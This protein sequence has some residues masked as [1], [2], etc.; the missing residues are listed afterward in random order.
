MM[1]RPQLLLLKLAEE[2]AEVSQIALKAAQFGLDD[3]WEKVAPL[4]VRDRLGGELNDL[5]GVVAMLN[6][7][8]AL[9][10]LADPGKM[11]AKAEK[12]NRYAALS[13]ALG[14]LEPG[15]SA[16]AVVRDPA[17]PGPDCPMCKGEC[18]LLCGAG[19]S[20]SAPHCDHDCLDRH[21]E[22]DH[23]T[24]DTAGAPPPV[25]YVCPTPG[26]G[27][28]HTY[29]EHLASCLDQRCLNCDCASFRDFIPVPF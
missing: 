19:I 25:S 6:Q 27:E 8:A 20:N 1:T 2:A 4:S 17:C 3:V 9:G 23:P 22:R 29:A 7:D 24:A 10:F 13:A 5:L 15:G 18:C 14:L 26:C 12:V 21:R 11:E 16:S 28:C